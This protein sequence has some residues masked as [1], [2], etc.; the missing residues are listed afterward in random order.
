MTAGSARAIIA[1]ILADAGLFDDVLSCRILSAHPG[2]APQGFKPKV[3]TAVGDET[4][5]MP[6][7]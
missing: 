1:A 6:S 4:T 5:S 7:A 3:V 2:E